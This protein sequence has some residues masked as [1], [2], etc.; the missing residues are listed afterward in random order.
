MVAFGVSRNGSTLHSIGRFRLAAE[1]QQVVLVVVALL[2]R[3]ENAPPSLR[4]HLQPILR[5]L[6][7]ALIGDQ[8]GRPDTKYSN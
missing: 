1:A 6:A 8:D 7:I 2:H 5:W 3:I 4:E